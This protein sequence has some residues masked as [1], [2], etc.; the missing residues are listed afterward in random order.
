GLE[1]RHARPGGPLPG[2]FDQALAGL[3]KTWFLVAPPRQQHQARGLAI[4]PQRPCLSLEGADLTKNAL[5]RRVITALKGGV[6][7]AQPDIQL[8]RLPLGQLVPKPLRSAG[9]A[10]ALI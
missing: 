8:L 10:E 9:V 6:E 2:D 7:Q 5:Q 4:A 1:E 3:A